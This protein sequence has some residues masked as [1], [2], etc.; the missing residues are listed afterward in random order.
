MGD[1]QRIKESVI[2]QELDRAADADRAAALPEAGGGDGNPAGA[3]E[4]LR[5]KHGLGWA[6]A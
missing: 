1:L 6:W 5:R 3:S 2:Q 4:S